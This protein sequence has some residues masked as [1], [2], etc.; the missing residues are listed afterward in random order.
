[1]NL[2]TVGTEEYSVFLK[3]LLNFMYENVNTDVLPEFCDILFSKG[4]LIMLPKTQIIR[5][6]PMV[7]K[8]ST[9]VI[10]EMLKILA[11]KYLT[12]K[13][14]D[15]I[16]T[17]K[18]IHMSTVSNGSLATLEQRIYLEKATDRFVAM[19][20]PDPD[21]YYTHNPAILFWAFT[22]CRISNSIR[23]RVLSQWFKTENTLPEDLIQSAV[24]EL[25]L[26]VLI[27]SKDNTVVTN[28][29]EAL[30]ICIERGD[31]TAKEEFS[32]LIWSMLPEVLSYSL[33]NCNEIETN[34]CYILDVAIAELPSRMDQSVCLKVAVLITTLYSKNTVDAKDVNLKYHFEFV[35][36][37]LC[38][39]LLDVSI[40]QND[41][42]VLL[43]YINRTGFLPCVLSATNSSDDKVACTSLQLLTCII[44][45]FTKN[46]YKP[47]LV[48][49]LQTDLII[50]SL[51][52]DSENERGT[53]L[54][55]L[56][57]LILSSGPNTPI[58][59]TYD[60]TEQPSQIQ[61]C[62]ALRALMFRIQL[63][64]C[65]RDSKNQSSGGWKTLN[66]IFKHAIL[67]KNDS[68]LVASLTSQPWT[69][70]LIRFQLTQNITQEF[71]A[72]AQNWLN[73]LKITIK[74]GKEGTNYHISK[75]SLIAKTLNML[76]NNLNE[77]ESKET[78]KNVLGIVNE[79]LEL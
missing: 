56:I 45:Y 30:N 7:R 20:H 8:V 77:E 42:K 63:M 26:N 28:C 64:L 46:N 2:D 33:I 72:F 75:Y 29:M 15:N 9:Q 44:F 25:L 22:S 73:L 31:E 68:N 54:L 65:C 37:K 24:W 79:I 78:S 4:Y 17:C 41:D 62:K 70:T 13:D 27:Q 16:D 52:Q 6:D 5:N 67:Y 38:L 55:Q 69:H 21:I 66:S 10:G 76:K 14:N 60:L 12:V 51:R 35:C 59:L 32:T 39:L 49:E 3:V 36:L 61:Q 40:K 71:L 48:L 57:H 74:K 19:L 34:I 47:K 58:V 23:L 11:A 50:K 18:D 53:S 1:D 43:T